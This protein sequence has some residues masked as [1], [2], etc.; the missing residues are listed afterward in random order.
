MDSSQHK[1]PAECST[2]IFSFLGVRDCLA[3][4]STSKKALAEILPSLYNRRLRMKQK[5]AYC[6]SWKKEDQRSIIISHGVVGLLDDMQARY[7]SQ[8]WVVIP[9]VQERAQLLCRRLPTTH[10]MREKVELL[11]D[12]LDDSFASF[13]K[14]DE[15][16]PVLHFVS[17]TPVNFAEAFSM[18]CRLTR[19]IRLHAE[20]LRGAIYA[21][22]FGDDNNA[23]LDQY[24]GDILC[25]TYLIDDSNLHIVEGSPTNATFLKELR[26]QS[27]GSSCYRSW[28]YIHSCILRNKT[29][30]VDERL[31]LGIPDFSGVAEM[32][33]N[34][35]YINDH[36]MASEMSLVFREFGPLGPAFRGRDTVRIR[37]I[38]ARCL[39]AFLITNSTQVN[40][41][42]SRNAIEW[43]CQVHEQSRKARPM[44]VRAPIIRLSTPLH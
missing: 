39:F 38:P 18:C 19:A 31:R 44:T 37:D 40:G 28:V 8:E 6:R 43:L 12:D 2:H 33:P 42:T 24:I 7:P 17:G 36:F 34:D 29:F 32:I 5:F 27:T 20:V 26:K 21:D 35:C 1:L 15:T 13:L 41:E 14:K 11:R 16:A 4:G 9:T 10:P 23:L 3:F 22:P 30:S 25:V